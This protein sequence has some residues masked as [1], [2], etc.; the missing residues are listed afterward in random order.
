MTQDDRNALIAERTERQRL[1]QRRKGVAG[2]GKNCDALAARI[3][4]I[5]A[6][7]DAN[8]LTG[9][10]SLAGKALADKSA[11]PREKSLAAKVLADI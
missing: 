9:V 7:L 5:D 11:S 10:A 6:L 4:E 2:Y 1:Y 8:P 3:N